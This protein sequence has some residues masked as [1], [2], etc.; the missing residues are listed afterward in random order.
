MTSHPKSW[1]TLIPWPSKYCLFETKVSA[2]I[3]ASSGT[4]LIVK[5]KPRNRQVHTIQVSQSPTFT[6]SLVFVTLRMLNVKMGKFKYCQQ[7]STLHPS[8]GMLL[9]LRALHPGA[10][11]LSMHS[12]A[13]I[14]QLFSLGF[15][16]SP[17]YVLGNYLRSII[18]I[19]LR[20]LK[21]IS[22]SWEA[23]EEFDFLK[24]TQ[25]FTPNP[26]P[27]VNVVVFAPSFSVFISV[28]PFYVKGFH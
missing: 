16:I 23:K 15:L 4:D 6:L 19:L 10:F 17:Y 7:T 27:K 25:T 26:F 12:E 11:L 3:L 9:T 2:Y 5:D 21:V 18:I 28:E 1:W 8:P 24:H 22:L 13:G 14:Y 20:Q